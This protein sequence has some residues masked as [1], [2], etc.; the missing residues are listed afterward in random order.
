MNSTSSSANGSQG[1]AR[2]SLR[3]LGGF[4]L[5]SLP[6][7]ERLALPG[8]RERL[9]LAYL[10]LSPNGRVSRR[11]LISLLW[12]DAAE[13][14]A[15]HSLRNCLSVLRKALGDAKHRTVSSQ[16]EDIVLDLSSFD[17]DVLTFR[18]LAAQSGRAELEAAADLC[19]G[20]L[21]DRLGI[22]SEE[23]E[24][25]RR[26]ASTC[27][28]DQSVDVLTRLMAQYEEATETER[29]IETGRRILGFEPLHEAA[30]RGLMRLYGRTGR[31]AAAIGVYRSLAATLRGEVG[32]EPEG[33]TRALFAELSRGTE[34]GV[35]S[36]LS[37]GRELE[38]PRQAAV[39]PEKAPGRLQSTHALSSMASPSKR[40]GY[41]L[42]G[43][44]GAVFA[45]TVLV[46]S[47][48]VQ[49]LAPSHDTGATQATPEAVNVG[50]SVSRDAVAIGVGGGHGKQP[51]ALGVIDLDPASSDLAQETV[52]ATTYFTKDD[53]GLSRPWWGNVFLNSPYARGLIPQFVKKGVEEYASGRVAQLI[54][55]TH[56]S[57]D[58]EWFH[59]ALKHCAA[60]C[61]KLR[62]IHFLDP[63]GNETVPQQGQTF[64][65]FGNNIAKFKAEFE[66]IGF[67]VTRDG[68][69]DECPLALDETEAA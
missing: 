10:A 8:K 37:A 35:S 67:V 64:F 60:F 56:S 59:L 7:R 13:E 24:S 38:P 46:M 29:A 53:N 39:R 17:V 3:L 18:R 31:R 30:A 2:W 52:G 9:L 65:Y 45:G 22:E 69:E 21:L 40:R 48:G 16:G 5:V 41:Q 51:E 1:T 54:M 63:E 27:H 62:R 4:D 34:D 44:V 12:E 42:V 68:W 15:L 25:W 14:A 32:A 28:Q 36:L 47:L 19:S 57:T 66:T 43:I 6:G 58:T 20:D 50:T 49:L 23:F 11:K 33:E 61:H 26:T 55:L